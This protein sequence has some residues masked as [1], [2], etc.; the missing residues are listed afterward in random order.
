MLWKAGVP[1]ETICVILG[2]EDIRTTIKYLGL[3]LDDQD[4]AMHLASEYEKSL[5]LPEKVKR[6]LSQRESGPKEIWE[7]NLH[8]LRA[9]LT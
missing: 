2:H 9:I 7:Y 5:M 8:W 6:G 3:S 1:I 4:E